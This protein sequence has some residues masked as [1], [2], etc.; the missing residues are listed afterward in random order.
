LQRADAATI[1][2]LN[3]FASLG[4]NYDFAGTDLED[5]L[6]DAKI[7]SVSGALPTADEAHLA[8][9]QPY[10]W[11]Y[12]PTLAD[13]EAS[14]GRWICAKLAKGK[15]DFAG[16]DEKGKDRKF[17]V[18]VNTFPDFQT[19]TQ[20]LDQELQRCGVQVAARE[21]VPY[22]GQDKADVAS[23]IDTQV[24]DLK[25]KGVTTVIC[26]CHENAAR[27]AF[28]PAAGRQQYSPEW[29]FTSFLHNDFARTLTFPAVKAPDQAKDQMA[30]AFGLSFEPEVRDTADLSVAKAVKA[31]DAD[32]DWGGLKAG[33]GS[34][35]A[36]QVWDW[37]YYKSLLVLA[38]GIQAAGPNLTPETFGQGLQSVAFPGPTSTE[39]R[40]S[41][42]GDHTMMED[43]A[44]VWWDPQ[45]PSAWGDDNSP[46][47]QPQSYGPGTWCYA[48]GGQRTGF[49]GDWSKA[50]APFSGPCTGAIG[51]PPPGG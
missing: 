37:F 39:G 31:V 41:F 34:K 7:V 14:T 6:A 1:K 24:L 36:S 46:S 28:M 20:P 25:T 18:I 35:F 27:A 4:K 21:A 15:A 9:R 13:M 26:L 42:K 33:Q 22:T 17:G 10:E 3:A 40:V 38:T 11:Y 30:H 47:Q 29:L 44:V 2:G 16:G 12:P 5:A 43:A 19:A 51:V 45:S 23:D 49:A 50:P 32:F 8:G 48:G